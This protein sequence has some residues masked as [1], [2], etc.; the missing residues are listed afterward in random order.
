MSA[1]IENLTE[2]DWLQIEQAAAGCCS[3]TSDEWPALRMAIEK[4][5][6]RPFGPRKMASWMQGFCEGVIIQAGRRKGK[7]DIAAEAERMGIKPHDPIIGL[8][9]GQ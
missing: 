3:G 5:T 1:M 4:I 6:G 2:S 9:G 8:I 7:I